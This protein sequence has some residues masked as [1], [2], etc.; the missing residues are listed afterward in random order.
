MCAITDLD[1]D[2][3]E[4]LMW[5][6]RCIELDSGRE[7][8]CADRDTYRGHSDVVQPVLDPLSGNWFLYTLRESDAGVS[9]RVALFDENGNRVWGAVDQGHMDMGWVARLGD[10][11]RLIASAIRIGHKTCGPD[12]RF[13]TGMTEFAFDALT[14]ESVDLPFSTYRT[15]PVDIDGDGCHELVRGSASGGGEVIDGEGN[16]IADIGAPVA[17]ACKFMDLPGEQLLAYYPDGALRIWADPNARDSDTALA[18][19][20]HPFY[21]ANRRLTSTGSNSVVLGGI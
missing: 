6:E 20:R 18:R 15:I 1:G 14:G 5:G 19:Y 12:G 8:F 13:H 9:P 21:Q 17:M 7:R 16:P 11:R 10:A 3:A 2:G 4:E